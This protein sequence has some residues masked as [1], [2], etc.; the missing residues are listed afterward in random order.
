M[1][2]Y[3]REETPHVVRYVSL[4]DDKGFI[5]WSNLSRADAEAV[6]GGEVTYFAAHR[7]E[8][9]WKAF[10]YDQPG[11]LTVLLERAGVS[12]EDPE[13]VMVADWRLAPRSCEVGFEAVR[14]ITTAAGIHAL[15]RLEEAVWGRAFSDLEARLL[16]DKER[17]PE[18]LR[19]YGVY[20]GA[21]LTSAAWMYLEAG[22]PFASLWGGS[23]LPAYRGHGSYSALLAARGRQAVADGHPYLTVDAGPM[24]RPILERR[25]FT[26]LGLAR[27]CQ[28]PPL[29]S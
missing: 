26:C 15:I 1:P 6:I 13:A 5:L 10:D 8:F 27:A 3:R 12:V 20:D 17:S 25:G 7:Q 2:G 14:E 11:H 23:T 22:S 16:R 24:S 29:S 18:S 9:E 21:R 19:L 4:H 28:S